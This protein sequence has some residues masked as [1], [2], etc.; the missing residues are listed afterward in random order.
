MSNSLVKVMTLDF[1]RLP[2]ETYLAM[3]AV[4]LGVAEAD[5]K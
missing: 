5:N 4:E 3:A 1:S 2:F